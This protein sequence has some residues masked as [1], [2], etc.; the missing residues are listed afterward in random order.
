MSRLSRRAVVGALA[1]APV[2]GFSTIARANAPDLP[3]LKV[4][5]LKT[6]YAEGSVV[7]STKE[8]KLYF[9]LPGNKG[10][11]YPVAVGRPDKQWFGQLT[12]TGKHVRPAWSPPEEIRRDNPKLPDVIPSGASNNPM[13]ERALTISPGEYAVHGTN[14]RDSI[15]K[16]ASYGCIRMFNE[17]I[18]DLFERVSVGAPIISVK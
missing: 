9:V 8:R 17:D 4:V 1:A 7:V 13:G 11:Q 12:I 6:N 5:P 2:V 10:I 16:F 3:P 15:G 14:R 18:I